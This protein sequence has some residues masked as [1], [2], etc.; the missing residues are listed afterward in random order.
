[1]SYQI[2][3]DKNSALRKLLSC[4]IRSYKTSIQQ[5]LKHYLIRSDKYL[6]SSYTIK[7]HE[8]QNIYHVRPDMI[9]H[10]KNSRI[11]G[12]ITQENQPLLVKVR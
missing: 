12:D 9:L 5:K 2:L 10:D 3:H 4:K 11:T 8:G 6:I 7:V 1:M